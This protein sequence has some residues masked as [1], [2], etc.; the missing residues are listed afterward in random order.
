MSA[1]WSTTST[2]RHPLV[3]MVDP[4]IP[5]VDPPKPKVD[6]VDPPRLPG[7][8]CRPAGRQRRPAHTSGSTTSTH[9]YQH[10]DKVDPLVDNVDPPIYGRIAR[11]YRRVDNVDTEDLG[12]GVWMLGA[13]RI[14]NMLCP[15]AYSIMNIVLGGGV[16]APLCGTSLCIPGPP[17]GD[18]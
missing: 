2:S 12:G 1:R 17:R 5:H 11:K 7:Q 9:P 8:Q 4:F 6:N 15:G 16:L 3:D 14:S 13:G 10:F 18:S